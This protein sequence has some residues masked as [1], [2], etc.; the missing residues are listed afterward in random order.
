MLPAEATSGSATDCCVALAEWLNVSVPLFPLLLNQDT[1]GFIHL[2][3]VRIEL[4]LVK[5]L[6]ITVNINEDCWQLTK[7]LE[8]IC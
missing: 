7:N 3:V 4:A 1:R 5:P 2:S 8:K 6:V